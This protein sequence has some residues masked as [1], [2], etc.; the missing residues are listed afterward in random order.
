MGITK[1]ADNDDFFDDDFEDDGDET[2]PFDDAKRE[3]RAS[4]RNVEDYMEKRRLK[5]YLSEFY[6]DEDY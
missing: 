4:W 5:Q 1:S 6:D 2:S 3:S